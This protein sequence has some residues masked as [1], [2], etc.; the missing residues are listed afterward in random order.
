MSATD[1]DTAPGDTNTNADYLP[2]QRWIMLRMEGART[3]IHLDLVDALPANEKPALP[4]IVP[5]VAGMITR[6]GDQGVE[7]LQEPAQAPWNEA[8]T[9]AM[10]KDSEGNTILLSSD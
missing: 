3:K 4:L 5:D 7:I 8:T 9:F 6:L 10:F 2:G 1:S